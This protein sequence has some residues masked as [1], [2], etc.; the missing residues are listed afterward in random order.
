MR[1]R[2]PL[3]KRVVLWM[4]AIVLLLA[5]Y[6]LGAPFA[7]FFAQ[8]YLPVAVAQPVFM[9]VYAPLIYVSHDPNAPGHLEFVAYLNWC[10]SKLELHPQVATPLPAQPA[11]S[12]PAS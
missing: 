9:V 6:I 10:R 3:L 1:P 12:V 2:R 7:A 5:S 8:K 4:A 11:Q